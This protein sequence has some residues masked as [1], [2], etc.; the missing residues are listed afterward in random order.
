MYPIRTDPRFGVYIFL[1]RNA[2]L[3]PDIAMATKGKPLAISAPERGSSLQ[4]ARC[5][6]QA[7]VAFSRFVGAPCGKRTASGDLD[8]PHLFHLADRQPDAEGRP[9]A[10]FALDLDASTMPAHDAV[11]Q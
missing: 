11:R 4:P 10:H 1:E 9:D 5:P 7:D 2:G 8:L 3:E 6:L